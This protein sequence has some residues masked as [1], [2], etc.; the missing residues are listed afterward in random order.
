MRALFWVALAVAA[1][2]V[3]VVFRH[4]AHAGNCWT[5]CQQGAAGQSS[6]YTHCD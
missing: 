2:T 4:S 5:Q 3:L 1:I 6:C